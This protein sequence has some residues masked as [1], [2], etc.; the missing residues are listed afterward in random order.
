MAPEAKATGRRRLYGAFAGRGNGGAQNDP[1]RLLEGAGGDRVIREE[2]PAIS[3]WPRLRGVLDHSGEMFG[4]V[5]LI[6]DPAESP[7]LLHG[8]D[9]RLFPAVAREFGPVITDAVHG[10][11]ERDPV[12]VD[13]PSL[14]APVP[15]EQRTPAGMIHDH[16]REAPGRFVD[17][18]DVDRGERERDEPE[19]EWPR[20]F[21]DWLDGSENDPPELSVEGLR[22]RHNVVRPE[23]RCPL[24]RSPIK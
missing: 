23:I 14:V 4:E 5:L 12:V 11:D 8:N 9:L 6:R 22:V 24:G 19:A 18:L 1:E 13:S 10:S 20:R 16:R 15:K 2:A 21:E 7:P 17:R 3:G